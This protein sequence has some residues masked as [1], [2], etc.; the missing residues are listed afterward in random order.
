LGG[1]TVFVDVEVVDAP[2]DYNLFLGRSFFY[3]M[4]FIASSV[5]RCV[6]FPYQGKIVTIDQLDYCTL[7]ACTPASNN[8]PFLEYTKITYE[9]VGV[10]LLKY[11]SLMVT[12]PAPLPPTIQHISMINMILN[13]AYQSFKLSNPWVVPSPLE[14]DAL[15]DAMPLSPTKALYDAIQ[16]ASPSLDGQH[17][18][19]SNTYSLPS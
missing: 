13:M 16:Y 6:Q 3:A 4:T 17:L 19:A 14:F 1:K 18:L 8:I 15:G 7:D 9:S 11:Y 2:L 5:F 12:F 10:G